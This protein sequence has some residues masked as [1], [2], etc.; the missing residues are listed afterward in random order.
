MR[1]RHRRLV[2]EYLIDRN[3]TQ[4]AIR[5]GY[6]PRTAHLNITRLMRHPDVVAAIAAADAAAAARD[7]PVI[8]E[9]LELLA[10]VGLADPR[11]FLE[12]GPDGPRLRPSAALGRAERAAIAEIAVSKD[13]AVSLKLHRKQPALEVLARHFAL[14]EASGAA[15]AMAA[16]V[17]AGEAARQKIERFIAAYRA[18][19]AAGA[20][21]APP[22]AAE[23]AG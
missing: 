21:P 13:G 10:A 4:A 14:D 7:Q 12:A 1:P 16:S 8:A 3:A 18:A 23:D 22:G 2:E 15:E 17:A 5:A 19:A 20:S 9:V 11:R 6:S